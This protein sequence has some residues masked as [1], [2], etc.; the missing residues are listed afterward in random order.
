M[1]KK[2]LHA[3]VVIVLIMAPL[4]AE[5]CTAIAPT[6]VRL[7]GV[8]IAAGAPV[9]FTRVSWESSPSVVRRIQQDDQGFLW[10]GADFNLARF[11]SLRGIPWHH[12]R[13]GPFGSKTRAGR[14]LRSTAFFVHISRSTDCQI[15]RNT[16]TQRQYDTEQNWEGLGA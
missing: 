14:S 11:D 7:V 8:P 4:L 6:K 12:L 16:E 2:G 5:G 9:R 3:G 15:G 13:V 10:F 1:F